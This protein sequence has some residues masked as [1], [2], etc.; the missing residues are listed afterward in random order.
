MGSTLGWETLSKILWILGEEE[1][2]QKQAMSLTISLD[3]VCCTHCKKRGATVNRRK[4]ALDPFYC[5]SCG[6]TSA[7]VDR[8]V[9]PSVSGLEGQRESIT[10]KV[11]TYFKAELDEVAL[12]DV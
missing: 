6:K 9:D 12:H 1:R 7:T 8:F 5:N 11:A 2:S 10:Q 4:H 3:D